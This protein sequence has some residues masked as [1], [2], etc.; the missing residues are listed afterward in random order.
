MSKFPTTWPDLMADFLAVPTHARRAAAAG[1][2][3]SDKALL[4]SVHSQAGSWN[5]VGRACSE[6]TST[7]R[8]VEELKGKAET[9]SFCELALGFVASYAIFASLTPSPLPLSQKNSS[10]A[11]KES[12]K[13]PNNL[14]TSAK[15]QTLNSTHNSSSSPGPTLV[16]LLLLLPKIIPSV[17]LVL[18]QL[19]HSLTAALTTRPRLGLHVLAGW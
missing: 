17:I 4:R 8:T 16:L 3:A 5:D 19:E 15:D 12:S 13:G 2:T 1:W 11:Q 10:P 18:A 9:V 6:Q 14:C 7:S